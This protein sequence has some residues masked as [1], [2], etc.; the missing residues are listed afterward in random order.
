MPDI[1]SIFS[2]ILFPNSPAAWFG[3]SW[4]SAAMLL[5]ILYARFVPAH[6][7]DEQ[8]EF[9]SLV[10]RALLYLIE[11][12]GIQLFLSG[13]A[14]MLDWPLS[15]MTSDETLTF[16]FFRAQ[17][18]IA[19]GG[20]F[21][22]G[23]GEFFAIKLDPRKSYHVREAVSGINVLITLLAGAKYTAL[24]FGS[25]LA[26]LPGGAFHLPFSGMLVYLPASIVLVIVHHRMFE[27][28]DS[29]WL[30]SWLPGNV[31][32]RADSIAQSA[33]GALG[34][35]S[36]PL[37]GQ[38]QTPQTQQPSAGMGAAPAGMG[39][40]PA[41]MGAAPA[42]MGAAPATQQPAAGAAPAAPQQA[43]APSADAHVCPTCG[44][45]STFYPQYNRHYCHNCQKWL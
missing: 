37:F 11:I 28:P 20:L 26:A 15:K 31:A 36:S 43:A 27:D 8:P 18:G 14:G 9:D 10:L 21:F 35:G 17:L 19:L 41:G 24:F 30:E 2:R 25:M 39:A 23:V 29:P 44:K 34:M 32:S 4:M 6:K 22:A 7:E 5:V 42:G 45:P 38:Q 1:A 33:G 40:A 12:Y 16:K 13:V 3:I